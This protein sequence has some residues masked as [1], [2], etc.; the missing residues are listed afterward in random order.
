M[1]LQLDGSRGRGLALLD[2][3]GD[4]FGAAEHDGS[5]SVDGAQTLPTGS[6]R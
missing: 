6:T 4:Q 3:F 5:P 2:A 1:P